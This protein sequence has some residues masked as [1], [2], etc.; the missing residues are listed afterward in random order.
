MTDKPR[1][2]DYQP[3]KVEQEDDM[4]VSEGDRWGQASN[5]MMFSNMTDRSDK[6]PTCHNELPLR[7]FISSTMADLKR[8]REIAACTV[9]QLFGATPWLFERSEASSQ[10]PQH[11]YLEQ[12]RKADIVIWLVASKTSPAVADEI[13]MTMDHRIPL[14]TFCLPV[15][16]RDVATERLLERTATYAT[17]RTVESVEALADHIRDALESEIIHG[18]RAKDNLERR[19]HLCNLK[20]YSLELLKR[21]WESLEVPQTMADAFA[22]DSLVGDVLETPG[23]GA[24]VAIGVQGSGK[25]LALF[26]QFQ[27]AVDRALLDFT[28][29]FPLLVDAR[30]L[31]GRNL[32]DFVQQKALQY[33]FNPSRGVFLVVDGLDEIGI[34]EANELLKHTVACAEAN[35]NSTFLLAGRPLPGLNL[36][37]NHLHTMSIPK[38]SKPE[39]INLIEKVAER[40]V[41]PGWY[42]WPLSIQEAAMN[43]LF[44]VMIGA[45]LRVAH[46]FHIPTPVQLIERLAKRTYE[47]PE[48]MKVETYELLKGLAVKAVS[49]GSGVIAGLVSPRLYDCNALSNSR[50]VINNNGFLD[51]TLAVFREWF[52]VRALVEH[53][54]SVDEILPVLDRWFIPLRMTLESNNRPLVYGILSQLVRSDPG[55]ASKLLQ[56]HNNAIWYWNESELDDLGLTGDVGRAVWEAMEAWRQ[57]LGTLFSMIGPTDSEGE[58]STLGIN[59]S[60]SMLTTS[61]HT[62]KEPLSKIVDLPAEPPRHADWPRW[63]RQSPPNSLVWDVLITKDWL[64]RS[65]N[66]AV[67]SKLFPLETDFAVHELVWTLS[68]AFGE[69]RCPKRIYAVIQQIPHDNSLQRLELAF[70]G[71]LVP[72]ML[73]TNKAL[74]LVKDYLWKVVS[75]GDDVLVPPWPGGVFVEYTSCKGSLVLERTN[76]IFTAALQIYQELVERWFPTFSNRLNLY[77]MMPVRLAG[78]LTLPEKGD[79]NGPVWDLDW[80]THVIPN[81]EESI[82]DFVLAEKNGVPP[83]FETYWQQESERIQSL[84]SDVKTFLSPMFVSQV[85]GLTNDQHATNLAYEWLADELRDLGW[86]VG[87]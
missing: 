9:K 69:P 82:T 70:G 59:V 50:L 7:V 16:Q 86:D 49:R 40:R 72:V 4:Q 48:G 56:D 37:A 62:G 83:D 13:H 41:G 87:L 39:A 63:I 67:D 61:W 77:Q 26:R 44:A 85:V 60:D 12:V 10:A 45:E 64:D 43:P 81:E 71:R 51:F 47:G 14:L 31:K 30:Q 21:M 11:L 36:V 18:Y 15:H 20:N 52:A 27:S 73:T 42:S 2:L 17:Y 6:N 35:D 58:T 76:V 19:E 3:S 53:T 79:P 34:G 8:E 29:P 5:H 84:R 28:K 78:E 74:G 75:R 24:Y 54:I 66:A 32:F 68:S 38:L 55:M 46:D 25:T 1:K 65:L 80:R 33:S 22:A 23:Q 57:G